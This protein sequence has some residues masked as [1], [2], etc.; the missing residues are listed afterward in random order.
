MSTW[1]PTTTGLAALT[2]SVHDRAAPRAV[3]VAE[4]VESSGKDLYSESFHPELGSDKRSRQRWALLGHRQQK[5]QP[6]LSVPARKS[7]IPLPA[8]NP[9]HPIIRVG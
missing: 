5:R 7:H 4:G 9:G 2:L 3:V 1:S 8:G 6:R